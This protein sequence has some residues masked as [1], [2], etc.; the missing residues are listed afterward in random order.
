MSDLG[1]K[2]VENGAVR[3]EETRERGGEPMKRAKEER[4][5]SPSGQRGHRDPLGGVWLSEESEHRGAA[6]GSVQAVA[7]PSAMAK[8]SGTPHSLM[9]TCPAVEPRALQATRSANVTP[10]C[11]PSPRTQ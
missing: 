4:N 6:P 1:V 2:I 9:V 7:R 5:R 3:S 11:A 8:S 10:Q